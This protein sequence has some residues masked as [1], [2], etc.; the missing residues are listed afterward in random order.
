MALRIDVEKSGNSVVL[1]APEHPQLAERAAALGGKPK[2]RDW[3]FPVA[4][5][6]Q[7]RAL[8]R[9]LWGSDGSDKARATIR[10]E[11]S[12]YGEGPM[13][14]IGEAWLCGRL[15]ARRRSFDG[16]AE[17]GEG[18]KLVSGSF[19]NWGGSPGRPALAARYG[20]VVD[21][22][23]VP[24]AAAKAA[25]KEFPFEVKIVENGEATVGAWARSITERIPGP[26]QRAEAKMSGKERKPAAPA[27][28][29]APA[30]PAAKAAPAPK[31]AAAA[32][33]PAAPVKAAVKKAV[34]AAKQVARKASAAAKKTAKK[35]AKK[36]Q[37]AAKKVAKKVAPKKS[38]PKKV[39]A[40][41]VKAPKKAAKKAPAR[42]AAKKPAAKVPKKAA[43]K[44][45][46]ARKAKAPARKA[47]K[48]A[49][50]RKAARRGRR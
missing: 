34:A 40:K 26:L 49:P 28:A 32:A 16:P 2:G 19:A 20:T 36:A 31:P 13:G 48:K 4:K 42:K 39:A 30:K 21:V 47:A 37:A 22:A 24:L 23:D 1:R 17:L 6:S 35:V 33:A 3:S 14:R 9:E 11:L 50:A 41:A 46:A 45:A 43:P 15:L 38:A 7:V 10:V 44:K 25:E 27:A 12:L 18:V 8:A 5:E 29:K